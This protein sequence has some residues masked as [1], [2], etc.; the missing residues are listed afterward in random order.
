ME[1]SPFGAEAERARVEARASYEARREES[2]LSDLE[3]VPTLLAAAIDEAISRLRHAY[4]NGVIEPRGQA[5]F[6]GSSW[7]GKERYEAAVVEAF[8]EV[9]AR[10]PD[11]T[12][13][14]GIYI[15]EDYTYAVCIEVTA[16]E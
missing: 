16:R 8:T 2:A 13:T 7:T 6:P 3:Q 4:V 5:D 1:G 15:A 11:F 10:Y 12:I 9:E 14:W